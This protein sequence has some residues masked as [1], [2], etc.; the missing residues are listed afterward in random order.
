MYN[1]SNPLA[2][3]AYH[4]NPRSETV[5]EVN[6]LNPEIKEGICPETPILEGVYLAKAI[7][8]VNENNKA[9]TTIL[10]TTNNRI[11]VNQIAVKLRKI[12]EIDLTNDSTQILRV[13]RNPDLSNRLKLLHEN[14]RLNHLNKEEEESVKNVCNNYND[15]F[16]LTGDD[17]THTKSIHHEIITTNQTPI[18]TKIYRFPKIHEQELNKQIAK[19]LKQGII[20]DSIEE[21]QFAK[22]FIKNPIEYNSNFKQELINC[23]MH[24]IFS[25]TSTEIILIDKQKIVPNTRDEINAILKENHS[26]SISG[27]SGFHRTYRRIKENYHWQNMKKDIKKFI[28]NCQSCQINKTNRHPTKAPMEITTT[29]TRPFQRLGLDI[30]GP[31]P[32]T[33]NGNKFVLTIQDDLTKYSF[34]KAIRNHEAPTIANE[35]LDFIMIFGL[36]ETI[37]TDNGTDF[38]S[39]LVKEL[40]KLFKIKHILSS[41]YHPMTNGALERSHSTLKDYLKHYINNTQNNWDEFIATA[42]FAYNTHIHTATHFTPY[43]LLFGHKA[44]I[45]SSLTSKPEFKYTYD[46]YYSQLKLKLNRSFQLAREKLISS[47]VRTKNQYDKTI[48]DVTYK[49]GDQVYVSDKSTKPGVNKKLSP[50]YKGPY[51]ITKVNSNQTVRVLIKNKEVTYH[52]NNLKPFIP[53]TPSTSE[54]END[55][56][57]T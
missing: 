8:K 9:F 37:L 46:D 7:L 40:N 50:K 57:E 41:P 51:R 12:E 47:K 35:F 15:I 43:E 53:G 19:M 38:T 10:N 39:N 24:Y 52:K 20:K 17:L 22:I 5:I 55:S 42:M 36:P 13:N 48:R 31:L 27:H 18:T 23:M 54:D 3:S 32:I 33:E 16:H 34:A 2:N 6:V 11:K 14:L 21:K 30:V 28:K 29:S 26:S 45:P 25:K 1:N 49:I 56:K 44:T 4:I